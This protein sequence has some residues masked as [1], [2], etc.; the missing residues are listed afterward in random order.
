MSMGRVFSG[1]RSARSERL[2]VVFKSNLPDRTKQSFKA[3]CD[4]NVLMSR[5]V[6]GGSIDHLIK[7]GASYGD[8]SPTDFQSAMNVVAKAREMFED[9]PANIRKRFGQQPTEF[10]AFIQDEKN[11]EEMRK[12]GL[13]LPEAAPPDPAPVRLD[14]ASIEALRGPGAGAPGARSGASTQ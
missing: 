11:L 4:L 1:V 2:P 12:L 3:E 13:A 14:A 5:Y 7:H 9:L 8:F 6:R 10:L